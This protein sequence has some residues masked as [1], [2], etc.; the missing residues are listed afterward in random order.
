MM[1]SNLKQFGVNVSELINL[2]GTRVY[3]NEDAAIR[4]LL[5]NAHDACRRRFQ[6]K[7]GGR[8]VVSVVGP[9]LVIKDNGDG[10]TA[11]QL[12]HYFST[13]GE[14]LT[15]EIK[16]SELP[17]DSQSDPLVGEFGIGLLAGFLIADQIVVLTKSV[18]P[19]SRGQ[20][21][22][23]DGKTGY[24]ME[25]AEYSEIGTELHMRVSKK[26][27]KLLRMDNIRQVLL[28]YADYL[29]I[30]IYVGSESTPVNT[31]Q[32]PWEAK[33]KNRGIELFLSKKK[34]N[35]K[36]LADIHI[37]KE[38]FP[39]V[40]GYLFIPS[41][42]SRPYQKE[43]GKL[44][45]CSSRM[46]IGENEDLLPKWAKFVSGIVE[47]P[48]ITLSLSRESVIKN[49]LV[50]SIQVYLHDQII[51]F[52]RN[53]VQNDI[54]RLHKIVSAHKSTIIRA[55]SEDNSLFDS[56]K[57]CIPFEQTNGEIVTLNNYLQ[58]SNRPKSL[59]YAQRGY[60]SE[61]KLIPIQRLL[62]NIFDAHRILVL[63]PED[64]YYELNFL[65]KYAEHTNTKLRDTTEGVLD[66]ME[67]P[68][69][70]HWG[71]LEHDFSSSLSKAVEIRSFVPSNIPAL[72]LNDTLY[73]NSRN[74]LIEAIRLNW[75]TP[76]VAKP[77]LEALYIN[78]RLLSKD[79]MSEEEVSRVC[80]HYIST[81]QNILQGLGHASDESTQSKADPK[82]VFV[83]MPFQDQYLDHYRFVIKP[84]AEKN[85]FQP[86]MAKDVIGTG[87]ILEKIETAIRQSRIAIINISGRNPNVM[88]EFGLAIGLGKE[89]LI[90]KDQNTDTPSDIAGREYVEYSNMAEMESRVTQFFASLST[91]QII[92]SNTP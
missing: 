10:M 88:F 14:S 3:Q 47:S 68:S 77:V 35:S 20:M 53:L 32:F 55:A 75:V 50:T 59:Y 34:G 29:S 85:G 26:T 8:I 83:G 11:E 73:L 69:Q 71:P 13:I 80:T 15:R 12:V 58:S 92:H 27:P 64:T 4:E 44:D 48:D 40:T 42:P 74:A 78:S 56:L 39:R 87:T 23:S 18:E 38:T 84:I 41:E 66:L 24:S 46:Y 33:D 81:F 67:V 86:W 19:N 90:L 22:A 82:R 62:L 36:S 16:K 1:V 7:A 61:A 63:L 52:L 79:S 2:L 91:E 65:R 45:L 60:L 9:D 17:S 89:V 21:W 30:D 43:Y 76:R 51:H 6:G 57:D 49:E 25:P 37:H 31:R 72:W 5:Q 28:K 70:D 54:K